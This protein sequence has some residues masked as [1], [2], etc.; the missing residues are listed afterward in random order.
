[1]TGRSLT[2]SR[3]KTMSNC[4]CHNTQ[5]HAC[6]CVF[7]STRTGALS[8]HHT[9]DIAV[10]FMLRTTLYVH[11]SMCAA[12]A[13]CAQCTCTPM[14]VGRRRRR[15]LCY[16][17]FIIVS[18]RRTASI[19]ERCLLSVSACVSIF[20]CALISASA[21][22]TPN[23]SNRSGRF[24]VLF[25]GDAT[26][27]VRLSLKTRGRLLAVRTYVTE[28]PIVG[29]ITRVAKPPHMRTVHQPEPLR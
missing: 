9:H 17:T 29:V 25:V 7:L 18:S 5:R 2:N 13:R 22:H 23:R 21:R 26:T 16:F 1:M 27:Q 28:M 14:L 10:N 15:V 3:T 24:C 8:P 12:S 6:S 4:T 11:I 20:T 19:D